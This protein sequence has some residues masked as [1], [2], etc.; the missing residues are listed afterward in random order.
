[1]A[2]AQEMKNLAADIKTSHKERTARVGEIK[3]ETR[4]I[5]GAANDYIKR[6]VADLKEMA[7]DLKD[8]LAKS[9]RARKEDSSILMQEIRARMKE[10]RTRIRDI[11]GETKDFLAKSEARRIVDFKDMMKDISGDLGAIKRSVADTLKTAKDLISS[12][13]SERKE[14][15][16]YWA[17]LVGKGKIEVAGEEVPAAPRRRTR[18]KKVSE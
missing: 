7:K 18:R 1:M 15:A 14:A 5:L 10:I 2:W 4:D 8:F 9:E 6:V 16:R 3:R 17:G 11:K 12:Y 13:T